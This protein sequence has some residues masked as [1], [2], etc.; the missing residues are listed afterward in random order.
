MALTIT[1]AC[2]RRRA[3]GGKAFVAFVTA[4]D[5]DLQFTFD[6]IVALEKSGVDII[7]LGL[8]FN[9]PVGDG[10]TIQRSY[11]RALANAVHLPE[12]FA[13]VEKLRQHGVTIPILLFTYHNPVFSYGYEALATESAR[14]GISAALVVDLPPE[15]SSEYCQALNSRGIDTVFPATPTTSK[16]RLAL[17]GKATS[18][19]CYYV[20]RTGVTGG[21][22]D[23]NAS[24]DAELAELKKRIEVPVF[25]GFGIRTA[26]QARA[27]AAVADG[28]IV[29]SAFID[30]IESSSND[31]EAKQQMI[32]L[33]TGLRQ[34]LDESCE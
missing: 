14:V 13:T 33:A 17:I 3:D 20:S 23:M 4:G 6:I 19:F 1:Q 24:L 25:V 7:E 21:K 15:E 16:K 30:C 27:F 2:E 12:L 8:P 11:K 22:Q 26:E 18:G 10:P 29:G 31:A 9:Y 32:A 28:V 34:A 5:P